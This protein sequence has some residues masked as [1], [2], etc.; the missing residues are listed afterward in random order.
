[1]IVAS[2]L[3]L[4]AAAVGLRQAGGAAPTH[5]ALFLA[6]GYFVGAA[7]FAGLA[8]YWRR[9][10]RAQVFGQLAVDMAAVTALVVSAGGVAS[11]WVI[12]YLLPLAGASLLLPPLQVFFVCSIAVLAILID[13]GLRALAA[14]SGDS[15]LFQSG[16]FGAALFAVSAL[17]RALSARLASQEQLARSRG[18]DLQNQL[19]INRLVIAQMDEGVIVVDRCGLRAREQSRCAPNAGARFRRAIDGQATGRDSGGERTGGRLFRLERGWPQRGA[20]V[21]HHRSDR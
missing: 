2:A 20:V 15:L 21:E 8:L 18:R 10:F 14:E 11:G 19:A 12:L 13:A 1:M 7:L 16:I 17:L 3:V 9:H 6:L 5:S 4:G